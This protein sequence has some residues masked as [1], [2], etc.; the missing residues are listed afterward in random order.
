MKK[1]IFAFYFVVLFLSFC[2]TG[3]AFDL[4]S[5]DPGN[6]SDT[7]HQN[8][9]IVMFFDDSVGTA[10]ATSSTVYMTEDGTSTVVSAIIYFD[11]TNALN[12]TVVLYPND[13]L[14]SSTTYVV[15]LTN[16]LLSST[17]DPLTGAGTGTSFA[18][19]T[20]GDGVLA[21]AVTSSVSPLNGD[22]DVSINKVIS[23][24]FSK[25]IDTDTV[26]ASLSLWGDG[27]MS[28][29]SGAY[30]FETTGGSTT[31]YLT[32]STTLGYDESHIV[33][34]GF[35][36]RDVD[37]VRI[38][39]SYGWSFTTQSAPPAADPGPVYVEKLYVISSKYSDG[40]VTAS[41]NVLLNTDDI[42]QSTW[43]VDTGGRS[44]DKFFSLTGPDGQVSGWTKGDGRKVIFKPDSPLNP[45]SYTAVFKRAIRAANFAGTQMDADY[46]FSFNVSEGG[47]SINMTK[48]HS[49]KKQG[50]RRK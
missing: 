43:G 36:I 4:T 20:R 22:T 15:T 39:R 31:V 38:N 33:I 37:N 27:G 48:A 19:T 21:P 23:V 50:G 44:D 12:D 16:G 29:L 6:G 1:V 17:D 42:N 3:R 9:S 2:S 13:D 40:E 5:S 7:V 24:N 35:G 26:S 32:P 46:S 41:F 11:S 34:V 45:G 8:Y 18:F 25:E 49:R 30:S 10:S 28:S 47:A 14:G